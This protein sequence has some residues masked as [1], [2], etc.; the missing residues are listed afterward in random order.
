M[1]LAD[2]VVPGR[3]ACSSLALTIG[4]IVNSTAQGSPRHHA[5]YSSA[6][7]NS[8]CR[9]NRIFLSRSPAEV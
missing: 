2:A 3:G 6:V 5:S 1:V 7:T 4:G 8:W 9:R